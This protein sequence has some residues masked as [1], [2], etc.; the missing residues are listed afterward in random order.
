[1]QQDIVPQR[2][3]PV[4][5]SQPTPPASAES[6][7]NDSA[8][9]PASK[10]PKRKLSI[11]AVIGVVLLLLVAGAGVYLYLQNSSLQSQL[12]DKNQE[13]HNLSNAKP[14]N[15]PELNRT[16]SVE[17][18]KV[19]EALPNGQKLTYTQSNENATIIWATYL[20]DKASGNLQ[21]AVTD[22]SA[23][24]YLTGLHDD[25]LKKVCKIDA[26]ASVSIADARAVYYSVKDNLSTGGQAPQCIDLMADPK[27]NTD[28]KSQA[29]ARRVLDASHANAKRFLNQVTV[30]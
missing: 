28:A 2:R 30:K 12:A 20:H 5:Q 13:I 6:T 4:G 8:P 15:T 7:E 10:P 1:M 24:H 11:F 14:V 22:D 26:A 9:Q 21:L 29:E 23:V 17:Q 19:S 3:Q 27:T 18:E 16:N 25:L